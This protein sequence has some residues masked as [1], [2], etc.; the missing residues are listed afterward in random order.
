ME[1]IR[2]AWSHRWLRF[3]VMGGINTGFSYGVYAVLVYLGL[4][5]ALSNLVSLV[6]G[7]LFSFRTQSKFVFQNP[8]SHV[9]LRY[10]GVWAVIYCINVGII[11]LLMRFGINAYIGG[12]LAI[13]P[14]AVSSYF[15]QRMFVFADDSTR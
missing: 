1:L 13:I 6:L 9:F 5:F 7:I 3:L 2:Q 11:A 4:N 12:A 10:I 8:R 14:T 15:L